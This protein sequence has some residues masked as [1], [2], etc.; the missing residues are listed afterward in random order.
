MENPRTLFRLAVSGLLLLGS[1]IALATGE[2]VLPSVAGIPVDFILFALTLLGLAFFHHYTLQIALAGAISV[3]LYKI[4]FTSFK[5]GP[6]LA[7][8]IAHL[9]QEWVIL[10]NLF[11]LLTG[12]ALLSRHFEK[13]HVPAILPKYLPDDWKGGFVLL[14]MVFVL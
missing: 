2:G 14:A 3:A 7:G 4:V 10:T 6:G 1:N 12:F 9:G 11:C 13:S 5:F 8:F